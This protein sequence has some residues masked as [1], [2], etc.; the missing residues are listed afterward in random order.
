MC[1]FPAHTRFFREAIILN[2][3]HESWTMS[4]FEA[5]NYGV[6]LGDS[7]KNKTYFRAY[8]Q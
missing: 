7:A 6:F 4:M 1:R 3:A 5:S 8:Y 2:A